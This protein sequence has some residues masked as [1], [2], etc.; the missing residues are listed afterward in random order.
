MNFTSLLFFPS[1]GSIYS[2]TKSKKKKREEKEEDK[3]W[4][5]VLEEEEEE[6]IKGK[7][8]KKSIDRSLAGKSSQHNLS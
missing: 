6:E 3:K 8:E 2:L 7:K 4:E 5:K 1:K